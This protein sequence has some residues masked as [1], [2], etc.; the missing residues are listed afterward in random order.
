MNF[1]QNT[2]I[3]TKLLVSFIVVLLLSCIV[4]SLSIHS[5]YNGLTSAET[6]DYE[7]RVRY[8]RVSNFNDYLGTAKDLLVEYVTPGNQ[9]PEL[10][11][12]VNESIRVLTEKTNELS[13]NSVN[14]ANIIAEIKEKTMQYINYYKNDIVDLIESNRPYEA[15]ELY[16]NIMAPLNSQILELTTKIM[17]IRLSRIEETSA[18]LVSTA[19]LVS[20]IVLTIIQIVLSLVISTAVAAYI[21]RAIKRQCHIAETIASGDF[22][23]EIKPLGD[24][25]FG[26]LNNTMIRMRDKLHSTISHVVDLSLDVHNSMNKVEQSASE[27]S[28][29]MSATESQAVSVAASAEEMV[30]TTANIAKNCTEA[31]KSSQESA[32]LTHEGMS[33]VDESANAILAQYEK[34]KGNASTIKT[35]VEQSQKIGSIV[36]TIDE[37]AAQ[38]NLLALNAAIEAARAGEAGRG[39]AVV[40]DEVRA[41]ATRTTA[42]TQEI[43]GMVDRIQAETNIATQSMQSNLDNMSEVASN[44]TYVQESLKKA[45]DYVNEVNAQITQIAT[46]AEEQT[47]AN[48]EISSNMQKITKSSSYVSGIAATSKDISVETTTRL[49]NLLHN[50]KFF[51]LQNSNKIQW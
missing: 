41:L 29:A 25:E 48:A 21:S 14:N 8:R 20:I 44:T 50:L 12:K 10:A 7:L 26:V 35:L 39:F 16:L 40:A 6:M 32:D 45:L 36:G 19:S 3:K 13:T 2:S 9:T 49:Q 15:L 31:A 23:A 24:D 22:L 5:M 51:K 4:S 30:A 47:A 38:T 46:A 43:R 27:I 34:M 17:D 33:R 42:S 1:M 18:S 28:D 37:I 11:A